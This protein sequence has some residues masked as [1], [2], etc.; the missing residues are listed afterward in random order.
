M[1]LVVTA[2]E[3]TGG[4]PGG[5]ARPVLELPLEGLSAAEPLQLARQVLSDST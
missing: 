4:A 2:R 5:G 1:L 3:E